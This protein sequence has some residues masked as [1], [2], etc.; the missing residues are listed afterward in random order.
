[1][2]AVV[3]VA[4]AARVA[5]LRASSVRALARR[6]DR[7][8][9][10]VDGLISW[11]ETSCHQEHCS[12][13]VASAW[14]AMR[15]GSASANPRVF[16]AGRPG[17][18]FLDR[19]RSSRHRLTQRLIVARDAMNCFTTSWRRLPTAHRRHDPTLQILRVP[20]HPEA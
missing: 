10:E 8:T 6:R 1:M 19:S 13:S 20:A 17:T 7:L 12:S 18:G 14:L 2:S 4:K 16:T 9:L 5:A 11:P 3:M 15:S